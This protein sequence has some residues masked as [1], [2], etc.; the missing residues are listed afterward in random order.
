MAMIQLQS[1]GF[2]TVEN[3]LSDGGNFTTVHSFSAL[4][5]PSS[6][7]CEPSVVNVGCGAFWS[8]K[9]VQSGDS[10]PAD[11]YS[12]ITLL[13]ETPGLNAINIPLVRVSASAQTYYQCNVSGPLGSAGSG[14]ISVFSTVAGTSTQ[15]GST[16][17]GLTFNV[18]DVVR[19]TIAGTTI[20][21]TGNGT[22]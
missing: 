21:V 22:T 18:G 10:W 1:Y 6:G 3:P 14:Q 13:T 20:T 7:V 19:L 12:E 4:Q 15:I 2:T 5:V 8:G 11:Q 16:V 17:T 9:V